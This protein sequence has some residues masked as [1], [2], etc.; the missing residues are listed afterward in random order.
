M[1]TNVPLKKCIFA[2]TYI[3]MKKNKETSLR[4]SPVLHDKMISHVVLAV[5]AWRREADM[6]EVSCHEREQHQN[7]RQLQIPSPEQQILLSICEADREEMS[8][9]ERKQHE[10]RRQLLILG[11]LRNDNTSSRRSVW[12]QQC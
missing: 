3:T 11:P 5:S 7:R 2:T 6:E 4:V 10:T 12:Q 1:V 8:G 9:H